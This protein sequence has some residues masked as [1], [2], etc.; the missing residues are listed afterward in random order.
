LLLDRPSVAFRE[1]RTSN[2]MWKR[3][4]FLKIKHHA[5]QK[6]FLEKQNK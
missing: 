2:V 5:K 6:N 1:L 4:F 3:H